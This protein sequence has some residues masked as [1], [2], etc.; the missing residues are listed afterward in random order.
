VHAC[1]YHKQ[2]PTLQFGVEFE[3][4]F[5]AGEASTTFAYQVEVPEADMT[6]RASV[7]TNWT[8]GAVM[9][10]KLSQQVMNQIAIL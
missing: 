9:E 7:D 10:K 5:R 6:F 2:A 8:I 1:Y 4:N 3:S